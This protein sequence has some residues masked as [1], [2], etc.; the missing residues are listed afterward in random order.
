MKTKFVTVPTIKVPI[1]NS[2]GFEKKELSEYKLDGIGLCQYGCRYCSSNFGNYLR[3]MGKEF[4]NL[5][6]EQ[7]GERTWP[8]EDPH[9]MFLWPEIL[10]RI[11]AQLKKKKKEFGAG[12]TLV[13]SMLTD[14]FSPRLERSGI[15]EKALRLVLEGTEFRIRV[16]TKNS[17]VGKPCWVKF[18]RSFPGRF[19]VGLS[20]GTL[21]DAWARTVEML[22]PPPS[23]RVK[24]M[25]NLQDAGVPTYGMLCPVFPEVLEGDHLERLVEAI[26]PGLVEDFWAEPYNDRK[27][28]QYLRDA[29]PESSPSYQWL[30]DVFQ[31]KQY[32]RW[33]DYAT[34]VYL[35][36]RAIA[37]RDGWLDKL[38]YLLYE[39][40]IT[41]QDAIRFGDLAGLLLQSKTNDDGSSK[42]PAFAAIQKRLGRIGN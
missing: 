2:P 21:N 12:K 8:A 36:I 40:D 4:A 1:A 5:T 18:F 24:A 7:T 10:E 11:E 35:R 15:T 27:N 28:W 20:I 3:I 39:G 9:L 26:R 38:K 30:T 31:K 37:E 32:S 17:I 33:S 16:L 29:F 13:Y 22:T 6:E 19:V 41:P 34:E 42:N 14:G 25:R 23:S